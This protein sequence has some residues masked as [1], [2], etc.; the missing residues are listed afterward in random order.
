MVSTG[1]QG[2][3]WAG[4]GD[5]GRVRT[6]K[7]GRCAHA[8]GAG[9]YRALLKDIDG[10]GG[11]EEVG[12][13]RAERLVGGLAAMEAAEMAAATAA[14]AAAV[15]AVTAAAA[16]AACGSRQGALWSVYAWS[17]RGGERGACVGG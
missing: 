17:V 3:A 16:A 10:N 14:M 8:Q 12:G 1:L 15:A 4:G 13:R 11:A 5:Q 2:E 9:A 6:A 7:V